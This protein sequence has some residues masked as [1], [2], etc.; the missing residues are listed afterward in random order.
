EILGPILLLFQTGVGLLRN[1]SLLYV[2]MLTLFTKHTQRPTDLILN[3]LT[4]AN[5]LVLFS[6]GIPQTLDA[7]GLKYFLGEVESKL[8]YS[9]SGP[10]VSLCTTCLLSGFQAITI[11]PS[12]SRCAK[13]KLKAPTFVQPAYSLCWILHL[14]INIVV[15]MKLTHPGNAINMTEKYFGLCSSKRPDSFLTSLYAF[16]LSFLDILCLVP[17]GWASGSIVLFL[18]R[19]KQ[20][21]QYTYHTSLSPRASPETSATHTVL[22]LVGSFVSFYSLSSILSLYMMCFVNP[23]LQLVNIS[24]FLV[25]CF[26]AFNP[27]ALITNMSFPLCRKRAYLYQHLPLP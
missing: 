26:P 17:M 8:L 19:H 1:S 10:G 6:R 7:L 18:Q 4:V 15:P 13:L 21:V 27:F 22:L 9:Q 2:Y 3:Q 12:N 23:S 11:S 5:F 16:L 20:R 14:L 25:A 24:A